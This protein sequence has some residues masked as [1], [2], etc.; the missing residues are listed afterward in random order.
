MHPVT[1]I[2]FTVKFLKNFA[3][4][5]YTVQWTGVFRDVV[6]VEVVQPLVVLGVFEAEVCPDELVVKGGV[7]DVEV[8]HLVVVG[9]TV[10]G[11]N[12]LFIEARQTKN[13]LN[14]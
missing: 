10:A 11:Q 5:V 4:S 3:R 9:G 7:H 12:G 13:K 8:A 6:R 1:P 2:T 14:Y